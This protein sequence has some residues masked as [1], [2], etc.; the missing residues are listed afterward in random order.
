MSLLFLLA[1]FSI[2]LISLLKIHK[3]LTELV[4]KLSHGIVLRSK[5]ENTLP[6]LREVELVDFGNSGD[7]E[8]SIFPQ[9]NSSDLLVLRQPAGVGMEYSLQEMS[10]V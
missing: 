8:S 2:Y 6:Y 1:S 4:I 10:K 3:Q 7:L 5:Q 9:G